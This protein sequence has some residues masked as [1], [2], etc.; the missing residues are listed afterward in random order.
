MEHIIITPIA[1][2]YLRLT[3]EAGYIL[4]NK[5]TRKHYSE[6]AVLEEGVSDFYAVEL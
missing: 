5:K 1:E 3:P 4:V 6:A 2:G